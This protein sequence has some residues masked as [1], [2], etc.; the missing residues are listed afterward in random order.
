MYLRQER[1]WGHDD[2][3]FPATLVELGES[4]QFAAVGLA[5]KHWHTASP[6]RLTFRQAFALAGLPYF[7]PHSFRNTLVQLGQTLC[8]DPEQFKAWSQNLGHEGVLTTYLSYGAVAP[9]RQAEIFRSLTVAGPRA[10]NAEDIANLEKLVRLMRTGGLNGFQ[11][12]PD[13]EIA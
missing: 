11:A 3:L 2:P 5:R 10:P 13:A 9:Q 7:N 12:M 1:L 8:R 6:I 4:R